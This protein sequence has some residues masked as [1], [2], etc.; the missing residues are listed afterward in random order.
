MSIAS[1]EYSTC[2]PHEALNE[3]RESFDLLA[4]FEGYVPISLIKKMVARTVPSL[5]TLKHIHNMLDYLVQ[6]SVDI[7]RDEITLSIS[8]PSSSSSSSSSSFSSSSSS[9]ISSS[10]LNSEIFVPDMWV[11]AVKSIPRVPIHDPLYEFLLQY[12]FETPLAGGSVVPS[13]TLLS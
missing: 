11:E 12:T 4:P 8:S 7:V 9:S 3:L 10:S 13:L 5:V 2:S 1:K 6:C